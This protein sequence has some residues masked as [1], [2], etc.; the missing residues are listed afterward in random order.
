MIRPRHALGEM[1]LRFNWQT[2]IL[3]SRHNQDVLYYG[4]NRF[5]RS[6][7]KGDSLELLSSDLSKGGKEGNVPY[8]T[9]TSIAESPLKFGLLYAG[10]DDGNVHISR[11][12]GYTW[13]SISQ[14]SPKNKTKQTL[15]PGLWVSRVLASKYKEGRVYLTLNG[16][17]NDHF[18]PYL[19]VSDDYGTNWRQLGKDLPFEPLNVV[20]ED[21]KHDS[22]LYVGSDGGLYAS[23]D[24]G[25]SFMLWNK[26]LPKSVPVHDIAIQERENEIVLGTH[27][28]SLY[29]SSLDSVQLLLKNPD[30]RQK[31]LTE[32]DRSTTVIAGDQIRSNNEGIDIDCPPVRRGKARNKLVKIK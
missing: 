11:D 1:P 29:I 3:L 2:P 19:Y 17:R 8:G 28:R 21:P 14:S 10:T 31:K 13:A 16:Y 32:A 6:L 27:G 23:V 20:R 15:P 9:I 7:N 30:Y 24:A 18:L 22:I 26:G 5:V 12:G 25:S 4:S